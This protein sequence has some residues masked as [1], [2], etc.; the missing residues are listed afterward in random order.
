MSDLSELFSAE[1]P[2][3]VEAVQETGEVV[4]TPATEH[5]E[6]EQHEEK[7]AADPRKGLEAGIAAER[8]KRQAA[9][10]RAQQL[11]A[12]FAR[13]TQQA[14]PQ[15][16]QQARPPELARPQPNEFET[17]EAY[18]DALLEYGDARRELKQEHERKLK[19]EHERRVSIERTAHEVISKGQAAYEDF[20]DAINSGLG[21]YLD[22]NDPQAQTFRELLLDGDGNRAHD[23]AYFLARNPDEAAKVY[24]MSPTKMAR[25]LVLIEN[26]LDAE[27]E[28]V[29]EQSKPKVAI[30]RTLTQARDARSGQFQ[31]AKYDGPTP[32]DAILAHKRA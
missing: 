24:A 19:Q 25:A 27:T 20:D 2:A 26:K 12:E 22:P 18:E 10:Q 11:E 13:L 21:R 7:P 28:P 16:Q 14:Q 1:Q 30:P 6:V 9:E 15:R 8:R 29:T 5:E 3:A 23:V 32:L 4:A 17:R 31:P